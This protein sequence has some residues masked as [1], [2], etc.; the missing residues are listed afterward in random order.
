MDPEIA[1][2][3]QFLDGHFFF[4]LG[5]ILLSKTKKKYEQNHLK[6]YLFS[7]SKNLKN[8]DIFLEME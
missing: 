3:M 8:T 4:D 2:F 6:I 7:D 1:P 5:V